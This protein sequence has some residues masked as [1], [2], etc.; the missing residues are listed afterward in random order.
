MSNLGALLL[1]GH[2][3]KNHYMSRSHTHIFYLLIGL[4]FSVNIQGQ[5]LDRHLSDLYADK[6]NQQDKEIYIQ[7]ISNKQAKDF[8]AENIPFFECPDKDIEEIYYFRW[9]TYR[10]HIKETPEGF[11]ITEF[12]PDVSWA[13]KYN[14]ICCPAWFHF[15]EGRWLHEQRYLNDYA[16][17]W[18]RGGGDVRSYSFP[19]AN[20][21][22]QY[23]L[24]TGN[25]S[26]LK[27]SYP[28]LVSN[29]NGW[30]KEKFNSET[31]LFWQTDNRDGMEISIGGN[32]YRATINSYMAAEAN[33]LS[34]VAQKKNDPQGSYFHEKA[35]AIRNKMFDLLWDEQASFIKVL[36]MDS[37]AILRDVR[38]LHGYTP[39]S[40]DL[41]NHSYAIAWKF[42]MDKN[43]FFAP[44]GP[45]TAEQCHPKFKVVYEG[46]ECQWNGP[47]WPFAT[48]MT[49]TGLANLLNDQEQNY[50]SKDDFWTLL[51][52]YTK[53]QHLTLDN[54]NVIP[55]IDENLNP[56]TGDWISRTMLKNHQPK[57]R[58][59]NYN[60]SSFCDLVISG[61]VGIRP[62]SEDV[63]I[64]NPLIPEDKWDYFCLDHIMYHHKKI[65]I[66]YDK[67]GKK[68]SN[69][70]GF[71]IF[72]DGK[73]VASADALT[74]MVCKL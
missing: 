28:E 37:K 74:K 63:L 62:Q 60:H 3:Q 16:Y 21:I 65:C 68:Y 49:L 1:E 57:E 64:V 15:R 27:E 7:S 33:T 6:F 58:G 2:L 59:R 40:F 10:K 39:W 50:I 67:T 5:I 48:A 30:E 25:D 47:S 54:G 70:K 35:E 32:G 8:L 43:H 38:E 13:G 66:L 71:F 24:V 36:P 61:L 22:Y 46:H 11:I 17:Y 4:C 45:T 44:Y 19:I 55:W 56:F 51:K 41:A 73:R 52:I 14:G 34:W 12:L 26:I 42:L 23:F 29:F 53:S 9:W 31:G 72:V 18:L 69:G 20:A